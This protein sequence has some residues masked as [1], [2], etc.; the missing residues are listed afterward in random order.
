MVVPKHETLKI[1]LDANF[2]FI[3]AQFRLD[4][5]QE[6][7]N[8][9]NKRFEP[10]LLSSTKKELEGLAQSTPKIQKQALLAFKFAEKC[11]FILVDKKK[12]ETFDDVIVRVAS[13]WNCPVATNDKELKKRLKEKGITTIFL[14]QKRRLAVDGTV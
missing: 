12:D 6:L 9:L 11:R 14:R 13:E 3:P 8:L 10:I 2:F 4:I 5:F 7:E 1:I